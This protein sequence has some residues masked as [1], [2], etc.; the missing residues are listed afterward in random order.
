MLT[1]KRYV[2]REAWKKHDPLKDSVIPDVYNPQAAVAYD[3][4]FGGARV[5]PGQQTRYQAQL[6]TRV[7]DGKPSTVVEVKPTTLGT[8]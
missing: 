8:E 1:E 3:Y 4:K 2:G 7:L 6:P 5:T